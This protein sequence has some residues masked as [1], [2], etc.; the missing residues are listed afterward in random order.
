MLLLSVPAH[1]SA[2]GR[3]GA[4]DRTFTIWNYQESFVTDCHALL[5][6][7]IAVCS[8]VLSVFTE[9]DRERAVAMSRDNGAQSISRREGRT[10]HVW[11]LLATRATEGRGL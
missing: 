8:M 3:L 11:C 6:P 7:R 1:G 5:L 4:A 2:W 9:L 10:Q